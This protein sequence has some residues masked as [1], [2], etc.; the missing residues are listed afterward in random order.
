MSP[1]RGSNLWGPRESICQI[2]EPS[3]TSDNSVATVRRAD[4]G[5][6]AGSDTCRCDTCRENKPA[7]STKKKHKHNRLLLTPTFIPAV[8]TRVGNTRTKATAERTRND[9]HDTHAEQSNQ[10]PGS[11]HTSAESPPRPPLPLLPPLLISV[12]VLLTTLAEAR[13]RATARHLRHRPLTSRRRHTAPPARPPPALPGE[14]AR[15][16]GSKKYRGEAAV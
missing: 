11:G 6:R 2:L 4:V 12:T 14:R 15:A 7:R 1:T 13:T 8:E 16:E 10:Q 5:K 3:L 9:S